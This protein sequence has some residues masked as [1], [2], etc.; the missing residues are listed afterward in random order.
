MSTDPLVT[1][2]DLA[3]HLG[4]SAK[5]IYNLVNREGLPAIRVGRAVRFRMADVE[6]W[7]SAQA[8]VG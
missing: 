5:H 7:L 1:V 8:R 4:V 6:A 3:R 2:A